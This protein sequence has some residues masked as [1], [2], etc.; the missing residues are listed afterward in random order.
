MS[1]PF[2]SRPPL[3]YGAA[4]TGLHGARAPEMLTPGLRLPGWVFF[5]TRQE[6]ENVSEPAAPLADFPYTQADGLQNGG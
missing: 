3:R 5:L 6:E 1:R 2:L 4:R